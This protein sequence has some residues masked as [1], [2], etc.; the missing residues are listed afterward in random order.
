MLAADIIVPHIRLVLRTS[1][2]SDDGES[3][4][5]SLAGDFPLADD[6]LNRVNGLFHLLVD[7]LST[8]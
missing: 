8:V 7:E 1:E 5:A 6:T 3:G 4:M 2:R